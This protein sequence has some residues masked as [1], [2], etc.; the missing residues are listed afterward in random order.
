VRA[1]TEALVLLLVCLSPWAFGGVEPE[2]EY[3]LDA[4]VAGL[5]GLW[6][7]HMLLEGR[8]AWA[9]CPVALCLGG[10]ILVGLWQVYPLPRPLLERLS[11]AT[12][13]LND[14]LLPSQPEVLPFGEPRDLPA[15]SPGSTLSL[16]PTATRQEL[17]RLLAVLAVFVVVR[18]T[19]DPAGGLR[20]L[21][22]AALAN[23]ALLSLFGLI[24]FFRSP[25]HLIYWTYPTEGLVFGPFICRNHFPFYV[26]A[27]VGLGV[28]LL[29]AAGTPARPA[30]RRKAPAAAPGSLL[31][32]PRVLWIGVSLALILSGL[33]FSLSRGGLL[34]LLGG[35]LVALLVKLSRRPQFP[36]L[37]T[38]LLVVGL[39]LG[40]VAWFGF[41]YVEERLATLWKGGAL[42]ESR[43]PLW[44]RS[45]PLVRDFPLLGTGYGTYQYVEPLHR[46][47][48]LDAELVYE[49]AHNEYLEALVEGGVLRLALSLLAIGLVYRL[50]LRAV[51]RHEGRPAAGLVIGGLFA[52]TTLVIHSVGDFGLHL[53]AVALLAAVLCAYLCGLG[54]SGEP[55]PYTLRLG[56]LGPVLGAAVAVAVGWVL[57]GEGWKDDRVQRLRLAA[58]R[59]GEHPPDA[60]ARERK[61]ALLAAAARLAPDYARLQYELG[62]AHYAWYEG[63]GEG[64][65]EMARVGDATQTALAG[66]P[67]AFAA[68]VAAPAL[69]AGWAL[70]EQVRGGA[71]GR[72]FRDQWVPAVR[73][74]LKARDLCPLLGKPQIRLAGNCDRLARADR[75]GAYLDRAKMVLTS[76]PE[77]WFRFGTQEFVEGRRE[78]AWDS[79]RRSLELS[80]QYLPKILAASAPYLDGA[81]LLDRLLP[82]QPDALLAAMAQ[83][84]PTPEA[85]EQRKPFLEKALALLDRQ[86]GLLTAEQY[87]QRGLILRELGQPTAAL[88]A[89]RAALFQK[90]RQVGWRMEL[91]RLLIQEKQLREAQREL[92]TVLAQEPGNGDARKLLEL[93]ERRMAERT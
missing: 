59:L 79:W 2:I 75:P 61:V 21:S 28:G 73:H 72:L 86:G 63:V 27:C 62:Q 52:F 91:A 57:L 17:V 19:I 70:R 8:L 22:I 37:A 6:A 30:G 54:S 14:Q 38:A 78:Q 9:R 46:A 42:A 32:N 40:L 47:G 1:A 69:A 20:R 89:Y 82:D 71:E 51:R 4:G 60:A 45:L 15:T 55:D 41:H 77:V 3:L 12:T 68:P 50:G 34:A 87:Y 18:N 67:G 11:P 26:N 48:S 84:Y 10:L 92:R 81:A 29:L 31:Q 85:A 80:D 49:H 39:G 24:Q 7:L 36:R 65:D 64:L 13:R 23:G 33:V 83:L 58:L 53:P 90:P 16:Y 5:L 93:V 35:G 43:L 76:D 25:H 74:F 44:S 56:G 66:T 88:A